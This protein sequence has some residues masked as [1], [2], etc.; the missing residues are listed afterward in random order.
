MRAFAGTSEPSMVAS[1][2]AC[3]RCR[4]DAVEPRPSPEP[5]ED[6]PRRLSQRA[7]LLARSELLRVLDRHDGQIERIVHL[8]KGFLGVAKM[9]LRGR[10]PLPQ[11][12]EAPAKPL[13]LSGKVG[14]I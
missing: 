6:R 1:D 9:L 2:E 3:R 10:R 14:R 13:C 11:R 4:S 12:G 5:L 8:A 7:R